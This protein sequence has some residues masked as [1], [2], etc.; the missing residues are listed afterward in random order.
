MQSNPI[1]WHEIVV[2]SSDFNVRLATGVLAVTCF[3]GRD[4]N[5]AYLFIIELHGNFAEQF[6][7]DRV[8]VKGI[9]IDLRAAGASY[10]RL[11]LRL[12]SAADLDLFEGLCVS[13][14]DA[15][16]LARDSSTA[17]GIILAQLKRWRLF[18]SGS[19][20]RM[21]E[22]AVRGLFAELMFLRELINHA[23]SPRV[24]VGSWLGPEGLHQD[25][26][27][28]GTAVEIKSLIGT[29]RSV[30]RISSED[31]LESLSDNLFLRI[32]RLSDVREGASGTSLNDAV[33]LVLESLTD[34][35]VSA[36]FLQK[37]VDYG[38]APL[39]DYDMPRFSVSDVHSYRIVDDFPRVVRSQL[40]EGIASVSYNIQLEHIAPYLC[41]N[42]IVLTS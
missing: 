23:D 6:K 3:W 29:E 30:V 28:R 12:S 27:F 2:P 7:H 22:E 4:S 25:F 5:G 36:L 21:S 15:L 26:V 9:D 41:D 33:N 17:Y 16:Q 20:D 42:K 32:Y 11:I 14:L 19:K 18:L 10:Q 1:P 31:Q 24:A 8:S 35:D 34:P 38:Y 39:P 37:L 13:I 40:P